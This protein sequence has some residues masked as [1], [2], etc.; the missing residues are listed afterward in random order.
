[1]A[2]S[3]WH[4]SMRLEA[5]ASRL[6]RHPSETSFA[7]H[8][9]LVASLMHVNGFGDRRMSMGTSFKMNIRSGIP[10]SQAALLADGV[11]RATPALLPR[12]EAAAPTGRTGHAFQGTADATTTVPPYLLKNYWWAYV[13]PRA[14]R[15]WERQW[16]INL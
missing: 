3:C 5:V 15:F 10:A 7:R 14:V 2:A 9:A 4:C 13:H 12:F 1:M 11:Q 8:V 6:R 16:L